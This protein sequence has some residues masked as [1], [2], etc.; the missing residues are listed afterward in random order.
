MSLIVINRCNHCDFTTDP[1]F[2]GIGLIDLKSKLKA[3]ESA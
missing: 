2:L 1:S 3:L